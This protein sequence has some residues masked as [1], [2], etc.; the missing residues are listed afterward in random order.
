[1][2]WLP[3]VGL[4]AISLGFLIWIKIW[5]MA[6]MRDTEVDSEQPVSDEM[7]S[8][9]ENRQIN[10]PSYGVAVGMPPTHEM[11]LTQELPP[12]YQRALEDILMDLKEMA[13]PTYEE[14][15]QMEPYQPKANP[16]PFCR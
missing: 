15:I 4:L 9:E 8:G 5:Q 14:A 12:S 3:F 10:P 11:P 13:L 7:V 6:E 1:M 2:D 16:P